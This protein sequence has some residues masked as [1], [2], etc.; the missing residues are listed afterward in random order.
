LKVLFFKQL[1]RRKTKR[2]YNIWGDKI[3][4]RLG[5]GKHLKMNTNEIGISTIKRDTDYTKSTTGLKS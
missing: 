5:V 4:Q 1:R 2:S 3:E